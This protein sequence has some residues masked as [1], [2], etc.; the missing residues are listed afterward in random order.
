MKYKNSFFKIDTDNNGTYLIL[1]PPVSDGKNI[2][3]E[4]IKTYI[5]DNL[6]IDSSI[7]ENNNT[8][9]QTLWDIEKAAV[10]RKYIGF[11]ANIKNKNGFIL[12]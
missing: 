6:K 3:F 10:R 4:E 5:D 8:N 1:Y 2:E 12:D 11:N 7:K 9:Y